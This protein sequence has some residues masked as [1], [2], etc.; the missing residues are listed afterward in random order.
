VSYKNLIVSA[1]M[2]SPDKRMKLTEIYEWILA[3]YPVFLSNKT[4]FQNSI[5]HNLS[6]NKIFVK[7]ALGFFLFFGATFLESLEFFFADPGCLPDVDSNLYCKQ[8][9]MDS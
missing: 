2:S 7:V 3:R 9:D 5:R 1:I 8:A 4:G 6:L